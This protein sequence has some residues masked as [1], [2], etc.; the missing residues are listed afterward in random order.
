VFTSSLGFR[1]AVDLISGGGER[2][3]KEADFEDDTDF[4]LQCRHAP[5]L[6]TPPLL[7]GEVLCTV[8]Q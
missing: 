5:H 8:C 4:F 7:Y 6:F 3:R 2:G 1:I